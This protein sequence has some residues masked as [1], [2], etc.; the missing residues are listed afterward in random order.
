MNICPF[1][2]V[3]GWGVPPCVSKQPAHWEV[4]IRLP[5]PL[6]PFCPGRHS[7]PLPVGTSRM[8]DHSHGPLNLSPPCMGPPNVLKDPSLNRQGR[9]QGQLLWASSC[10]WLLQSCT[11]NTAVTDVIDL[12]GVKGLKPLNKI[13]HITRV[14]EN[15]IRI[16]K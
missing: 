4:K 1:I 11:H 6:R 5:K 13:I 2:D 16:S 12:V 10:L 9:S 3:Q 7:H 14:F 15:G 8:S